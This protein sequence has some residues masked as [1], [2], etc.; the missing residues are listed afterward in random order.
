[1]E[2]KK[3]EAAVE[4]ILLR[5]GESVEAAKLAKAIEQDVET[6]KKAC[7]GDDGPL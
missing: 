3:L 4:A 2:I 1:M 5:A 6:T 7:A